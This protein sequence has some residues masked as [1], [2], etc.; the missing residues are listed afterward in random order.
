M[1]C[2]A[3]ACALAAASLAAGPADCNLNGIPDDQEI[4]QDQTLDCFDPGV[5]TNN[6]HDG[7]LDE[8]QCRAD[9]DGNGVVNSSDISAYVVSWFCGVQ[10][11]AWIADF[12]CS[13]ATNSL[14][15]SAFIATWLDQVTGNNPFAACP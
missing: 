9:W 11:G 13:G 8:C 2:V 15:L 14:D 7:V 10:C 12:D 5:V 1:N 3:I 6:G 4:A